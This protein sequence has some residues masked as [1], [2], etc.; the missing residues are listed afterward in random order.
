MEEVSARPSIF[1]RCVITAV[2][3]FEMP[4]IKLARHLLFILPPALLSYAVTET[5]VYNELS[6]ITPIFA[7]YIQRSAIMTL[8]F[9]YVYVSAAK[10]SYRWLRNYAESVDEIDRTDV[11]SILDVL[12]EVVSDKSKRM[13]AFAKQCQS[14]KMV[15]SENA[16]Q[17]ITQPT[18]QIA[19]MA[20]A[21]RSVFTTID[22]TGAFFK[23]GIMAIENGKAHDWAAWE[24]QSDPPITLLNT[25]RHETSSISRAIQS[26]KMVI[27]EDIQKELKKNKAERKYVKGNTQAGEGGGQI[28]FPVAHPVNREIVYVITIAGN[29]RTCFQESFEPI[30]TW[31]LRQFATRISLE[32]SLHIIKERANERA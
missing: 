8:V 28:C 7:P 30:Y 22:R 17:T 16:F 24:P 25:L 29:R 6:E 3:I 4:L 5:S 13:A 26:G 12:N 1:K 19:I 14:A 31:I 10:W 32:H 18:T 15:C 2:Y 9:C 21:I 20:R 11:I 23:V 27:V